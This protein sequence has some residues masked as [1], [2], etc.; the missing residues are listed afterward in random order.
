MI[1]LSLI[2]AWSPT[3][4]AVHQYGVRNVPHGKVGQLTSFHFN[5]PTSISN[6]SGINTQVGIR[7]VEKEVVHFKINSSDCKIYSSPFEDYVYFNVDNIPPGGKPGEPQLP[8][9]SF[10]V[11][12]PLGS[13]VT[14]VEVVQCEHVEINYPLKIVPNPTP[15]VWGGIC[16]F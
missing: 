3:L 2:I 16:V 4:L 13:K 8:M 5:A 1:L 15:L 6:L 14:G 11:N 7:G 10:V 12:L 9:K